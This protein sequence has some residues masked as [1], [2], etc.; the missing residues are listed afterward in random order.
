MHSPARILTAFLALDFALLVSAGVYVIKPASGTTCTGGT[1]CTI[2]W[3]DDGNHPLLNEIGV[4]TVG[5]F[6]GKQQLV[7][8][9]QPLDVSA[10]HSVQFTPNPQAGPNSGSYYIAFTSTKAIVN[11][12]KAISFSPFFTLKGMSG[13]FSSPLASATATIAIPT[14]VAHTSSN[15]VATT[16]TLG[17]LDTSLPPLPTLSTSKASSSAPTS[18]P[19]PSA[20]A[21]STSSFLSRFT[22]SSV[23]SSSP[24]AT[25]SS[26]S[27][28]LASRPLLLLPTLAVLS[29]CV[30]MS[31][32]S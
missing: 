8:T 5:L 26:T 25:K 20:P 14:T 21:S 4:V 15:E 12:T 1:P 17:S 32:I 10:S 19:S 31:S 6:S 22:T 18:S 13:S 16:I 7:Q 23:S 27:D 2:E 24:S 28:A 11:G 30:I 9:I 3:L 29:L